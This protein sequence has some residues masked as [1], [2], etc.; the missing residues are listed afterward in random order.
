[1]ALYAKYNGPDQARDLALPGGFISFPQ[2][3]WVDVEAA[4]TDAGIPL[5]H[6]EVVTFGDDWESRKTAPK[7]FKP[8]AEPA[9]DVEEI[10]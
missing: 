4:A 8:A 1:M 6:L 7:G 3:E 2:G 9:A 5:Q 10:S